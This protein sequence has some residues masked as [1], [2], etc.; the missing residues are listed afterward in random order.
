MLTRESKEEEI[1]YVDEEEIFIEI[2]LVEVKDGDTIK[3]LK[4]EEEYSVRLIGIDSPELYKNKDGEWI[5]VN[6]PFSKE[7]KIFLENLLKNKQLWL[8]YDITKKDKYGRELAYLWVKGKKDKEKIFINSQMLSNGFA[9]L[10][11]IPPNVKYVDRL[12]KAQ[13]EAKK[14]KLNL[15][16]K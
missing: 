12:K 7:A 3:V 11:T 1:E 2:E 10:M 15:W 6:E 13:N 8:E 5:E 16:K 4:D 14:K 9:V